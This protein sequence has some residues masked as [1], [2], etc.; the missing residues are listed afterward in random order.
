MG[1]VIEL[2]AVGAVYGEAHTT[3]NPLRVAS[4]KSNIGHAEI[5]A[6]IFSLTKAV[7]MLRKRVFLPTA[8]VTKP[9]SDF[10][11]AGHNMRVQQ[12]VEPFPNDKKVIIA[13]SSFGIGGSYGHCLVREWRVSRH[14]W[15]ALLHRPHATSYCDV[16]ILLDKSLSFSPFALM[17]QP[18]DY[19]T[20]TAS[21]VSSPKKPL[22]KASSSKKAL[23]DRPRAPPAVESSYQLLP[24][25]GF[26]LAHLKQYAVNMAAYL[27]AKPTVRLA[28]VCG[29]VA[30]RRSRFP[31]RKAFVAS[32]TED[33]AAQLETFA[34]SGS[35][36]AI[37]EAR[38]LRTAFILTGQ[39][40]Q[41]AKN[42]VELMDSFPIYRKAAEV[43]R[44]PTT[45]PVPVATALSLLH[46]HWLFNP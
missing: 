4:I 19:L 21:D 3:H 23:A 45:L 40:S 11:W 5:A 28:D 12:T 29:T 9:R 34:A 32:S 43:S 27:R 30:L 18:E 7:E 37:G 2:E 31:F 25:S 46:T 38:T 41:W 39:G 26:S 15:V 22:I 20:A 35:A 42:G 33:L 1:D 14:T 17:M 16:S 24:L 6:G 8:G 10:D 36:D 44:T 13:V